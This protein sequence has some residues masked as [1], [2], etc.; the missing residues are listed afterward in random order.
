MSTIFKF[1]NFLGKKDHGSGSGIQNPESESTARSGSALRLMRI[2][3]TVKNSVP[4]PDPPGSEII[5]P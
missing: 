3:N 4:D 1:F 5:W 2:R